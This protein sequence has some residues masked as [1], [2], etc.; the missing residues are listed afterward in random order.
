MHAAGMSCPAK[1]IGASVTYIAN[2]VAVLPVVVE[3]DDDFDAVAG[4]LR[5]GVVN[6]PE[7]LLVKHACKGHGRSFVNITAPSSQNDV[8]SA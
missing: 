6:T 5:D 3:G 8:C 7:D 4:G 2:A 1:D